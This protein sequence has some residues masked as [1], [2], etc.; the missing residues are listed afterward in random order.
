MNE[1]LKEKGNDESKVNTD[2]DISDPYLRE[3]IVVLADL[4]ALGI[5]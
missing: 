5:G 1:S 3:S 4:I 2:A